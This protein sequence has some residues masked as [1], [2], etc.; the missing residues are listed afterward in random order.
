MPLEI[1][2]TYE[3]VVRVWWAYIWRFLLLGGIT[4]M[5]VVFPFQLMAH[6]IGLAPK[7]RDVGKMGIGLVIS[8]V[9]AQWVIHWLLTKGFGRYRLALIEK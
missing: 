9:A 3:K 2:V 4:N 7:M 8:I 6:S 1:P 5:V